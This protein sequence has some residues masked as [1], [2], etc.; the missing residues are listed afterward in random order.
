VKILIHHRHYP[1]S[2]GRYLKRGLRSLGHE[3]FSVGCVDPRGAEYIPWPGGLRFPRYVDAP[4]LVTPD[5]QAYPLAEVLRAIPFSPDAVIQAGDVCWLHGPSPVPNV[6]VM[7]DPHCVDYQ[8]RLAHA[9]LQICMQDYYRSGYPGSHWVPYAYDEE[10]HYHLPK[11]PREYDV[12]M[13]GLMYEHR[14][15]LL[16]R[17]RQ[18]GVRVCGGL[19]QIFHEGTQLYNRGLIALSWSSRMDLPARFFEGLAY[20]RLVI[21]NRLPDIEKL[22]FLEGVHYVDFQSLD[23]A[24]SKCTF[25]IEHPDFAEAIAARGRAAVQPH[26]W[27]ARAARIVSLLPR[28]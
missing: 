14:A 3:V 28:R 4:D 6:I 21:S 19:G 1:V 5:V 16:E 15:A 13:I 17:L 23:E 25:Y 26:T 9:D 20:G 18:V 22:G 12:V 10:W 2:I 27:R 7:T 8:P 24:V 11:A